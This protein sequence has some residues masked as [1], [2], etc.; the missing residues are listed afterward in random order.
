M[1]RLVGNLLMHG[2]TPVT[3]LSLSVSFDK[4]SQIE[5]LKFVEQ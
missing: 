2:A 1:T 5:F 3:D 4:Y